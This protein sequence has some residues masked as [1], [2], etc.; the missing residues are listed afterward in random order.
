MGR[1]QIR[2]VGFWQ[3][4]VEKNVSCYTDKGKGLFKGTSGSRPFTLDAS[5]WE[6]NKNKMSYLE[7]LWKEGV[8]LRVL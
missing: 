1:S 7:K 5:G 2:G 4:Q 3:F 6:E 8:C